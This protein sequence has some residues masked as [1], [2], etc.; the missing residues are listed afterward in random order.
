MKNIIKH[1]LKEEVTSKFHNTIKNVL[2]KLLYVDF[3]NG[4]L[5]C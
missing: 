5:Y 1:I 4:S 2:N 3:I